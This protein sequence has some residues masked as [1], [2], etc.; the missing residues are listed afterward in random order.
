MKL[1][2]NFDP[3]GS[4][5]GWAEEPCWASGKWLCLCGMSNSSSAR[6]GLRNIEEAGLVASPGIPA[7]AFLA[8]C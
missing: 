1:E 4:V 2:I 7:S 3:V 5:L 6:V 8:G